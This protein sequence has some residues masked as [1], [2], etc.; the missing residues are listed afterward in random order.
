MPEF[1]WSARAMKK[2]P[3]F[4][5][6]D[7]DRV[8]NVPDPSMAG[9]VFEGDDD[10][11]IVFWQCEN[12]GGCEEHVHDFWEYAIVVEGHFDGTIGDE[13]IHMEPGD[14]CVI[15]PGVRHSGTYSK[16]YRA[17]DAFS[18]RRVTRLSD[19]G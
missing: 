5:T 16:G 11:Q 19:A 10:V 17:I 3:D 9:F 18:A 13:V 15:E 7:A 4:I 8:A 6:N 12:G 1:T 14:E 2:F